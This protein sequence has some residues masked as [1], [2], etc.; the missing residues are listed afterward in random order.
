MGV[1]DWPVNRGAGGCGSRPLKV[2]WRGRWEGWVGVPPVP[3]LSSNPIRWPVQPYRAWCASRW[4]S[5]GPAPRRCPQSEAS[6]GWPRSGSC[7]GSSSPPTR[8]RPSWMLSTPKA[9]SEPSLSRVSGSDS[10]L[11]TQAPRGRGELRRQHHTALLPTLWV[12]CQGPLP[13][14]RRRCPYKVCQAEGNQPGLETPP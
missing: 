1:L 3:L 2:T 10:F 13:Q 9:T 6:V 11:T 5:A 4:S 7:P 12:P 8:A 14:T